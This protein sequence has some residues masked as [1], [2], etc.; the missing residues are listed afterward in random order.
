ML[1]RYKNGGSTS[2]VTKDNITTTETEEET[3]NAFISEEVNCGSGGH[4]TLS[5]AKCP[6]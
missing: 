2:W 1:V 6:Q 4:L 3:Q 5:C